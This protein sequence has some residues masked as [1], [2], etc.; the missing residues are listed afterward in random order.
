MPAAEPAAGRV[1]LPTAAA[2]EDAAPQSA[3]L[4]VL[5]PPAAGPSARAWL[6]FLR[7]EV[8]LVL[9]RRRNRAGLGV[10]AAI[11]IVM[12]IAVKI[13][14]PSSQ[15]QGETFLAS[16]VGNGFFVALAALTVEIGLFLPLAIAMLSG[17]AVAGE[18]QIGT[19]R[20]LLVVPVPRARLLATKYVALVVGS[21]LAV[22]VVAIVGLVAGGALFGL[23]P[24]ATLS[25][26]TLALPAA[27][28]RLALVVLYV[29]AFLAALSA[30]GLF[31]STL[32]EQP[33]G[34]T[35]AVALIS[36][37]MWIL[38]A[39]PQLDWLHPWLLVDKQVALTDLLRD[40]VYW[41]TMRLGLLTDLAYVVVFLLAAWARFADKDVSG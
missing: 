20:G 27:L 12:A 26:T 32:T 29:T 16:I 15:D 34:A 5:P 24:V 23:H 4:V 1:G 30:L 38:D 19:L 28:G 36:T 41:P 21:L 2:P 6:R 35:V 10:L 18:A 9:S 33:L 8:R 7:S 14:N 37:T 11:P 3:P 13:A 39:I 40:P 17:D 31:V 25:G 22:L